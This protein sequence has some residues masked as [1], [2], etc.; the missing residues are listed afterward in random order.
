MR[1]NILSLLS[2]L[3]LLL[4]LG[5]HP[6]HAARTLKRQLAQAPAAAP[7]ADLGAAVAKPPADPKAQAPVVGAP[8][9]AAVPQAAQPPAAV[10][11][12]GAAQATAAGAATPVAPE[13]KKVPPYNKETP[14]GTTFNGQVVPPIVD[15]SG[16]TLKEDISVGYWYV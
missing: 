9:A 10:A 12:N 16:T 8:A 15:L 2:A 1:W 13:E 11:A 14:S 6:S 7:V 4:L 5:A 3:V